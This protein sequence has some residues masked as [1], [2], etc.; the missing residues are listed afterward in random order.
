M[1]CATGGITGSPIF[2]NIYTLN[3]SDW[4]GETP[5]FSWDEL[6]N[7]LQIAKDKKKP[8]YHMGS[9]AIQIGSLPYL[10]AANANLKDGTPVDNTR[11]SSAIICLQGASATVY[12]DVAAMG[13]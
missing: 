13:R 8:G 12:Q 4:S 10:L 7:T 2:L 11:R 5:S 6:K 1:A 3:L 9:I